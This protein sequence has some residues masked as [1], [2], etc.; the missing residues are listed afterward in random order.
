MAVFSFTG[1]LVV[2]LGAILGPGLATFFAVPDNARRTFVWL[3]WLMAVATAVEFQIVL[4][5]AVFNA[6]E[7][8]FLINLINAGRSLLQL[9]LVWAFLVGGYGVVGLGLA[10]LAVT[11]AAGGCNAVLLKRTLPEVSLSWKHAS[12]DT[13][14]SLLR[15]GVSTVLATLMNVVRTKVGSVI[16]AKILGLSAVALY[17]VASGIVLQLY[18]VVI[19]GT[20]VLTARFARVDGTGNQEALR[21][22]FLKS[23]LVCSVLSF[24]PGLLIAI[25]GPRF[26]IL[27][28]GPDFSEAVPAL[29]V[30]TL[31]YVTALAQSSGWNLLFATEKHHFLA[32]V[33]IVEAIAM[34]VGSVLLAAKLGIVGV[35]LASTGAMLITKVI[36]QPFYV[37]RIIQIPLRCY[38]AAMWPPFLVASGLGVLA[39]LLGLREFAG[40]CSVPAYLGT[41]FALGGA[42]LTAVTLATHRKPYFPFQ[43]SELKRWHLAITSK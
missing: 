8:F 14:L 42:Y 1:V 5:T 6:H 21:I 38:L 29:Y 40:R 7:R 13:L 10:N 22:L 12:K 24:G 28:V 19:S 34:L 2:V 17:S 37:A 25:L 3:V 15:Y 32:K 43:F 11:L 20:N 27:W 30:L 4:Q 31:G 41:A 26:I 23:L 9:G 16:I 39:Y 18:S 33:S 36:V 35:A